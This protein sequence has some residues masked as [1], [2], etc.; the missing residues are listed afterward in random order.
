MARSSAASDLIWEGQQ[1]TQ[2]AQKQLEH[3]KWAKD[4]ALV[5]AL[6]VLT[7]TISTVLADLGASAK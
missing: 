3:R 6:I 2:S 4:F 1:R 7:I 5:F